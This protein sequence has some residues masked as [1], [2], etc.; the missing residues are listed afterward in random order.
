MMLFQSGRPSPSPTWFAAALRPATMFPMLMLAVVLAG[1]GGSS[2]SRTYDL[3]APRDVGRVAGASRAALV[4]AEPSTVQVFDSE[5]II[6]RD[7]AGALSVLSGAQWADRLPR[8]IQT[9]MIQTF[10]NASRLGAVARP[11]ERVLPDWQLNMDIRN[12]AIDS[13]SGEAVVE[14]SAKLVRDRNGRVHGAQL[15]VARVP[16]GSIDADNAA[17]ALDRALSQVLASIVRWARV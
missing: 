7:S 5:R 6:V 2:A 3:T 1:C 13:A 4:V 15:F 10:E 14:I 8:L 11:G 12:F 9:R 17:I 16:V